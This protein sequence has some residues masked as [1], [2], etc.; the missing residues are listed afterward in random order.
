[1]FIAKF[2]KLLVLVYVYLPRSTFFFF[3]VAFY[4]FPCDHA[5]YH[6]TDVNIMQVFRGRCAFSDPFDSERGNV[7]RHRRRAVVYLYERFDGISPRHLNR[8]TADGPRRNF[9]TCPA[10]SYAAA[11]VSR[12]RARATHTCER[13][14]ADRY[15]RS[16]RRVTVTW[17]EPT[18][19][20]AVRSRIWHRA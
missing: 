3:H 7:R 8:G 15:A 5:Y 9:R 18:R 16:V 1:M 19:P 12:T 13:A 10:F 2:V 6:C 4:R 14:P 20:F 11:D 17:H